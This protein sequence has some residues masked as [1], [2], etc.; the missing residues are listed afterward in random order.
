MPNRR[1]PLNLVDFTG[2]LNLRSNQFQLAA[3]ESPQME[4][5]TIDPLGGIYSRFGW[6]RWNPIDIPVTPATWDPRRAFLHQLA[7]GTDNV[8][9][10]ANNKVWMTTANRTFVDS[11]LVASAAVHVADF[12]S[13][14]DD[15]YIACG[16][17]RQSARRRGL[18]APALLTSA[19]V[20][21]WNDDYTNPLH[22]VMPQ[23]ALCEQHGGY[24][25][26]ART[27]EDGVNFPN[28][29][30]WSHPTSQ[31]DWAHDDYIDIG[32]GG[33]QIVALQ[34][35]EDHLLIF[36][37]DGIWALYGYNAESWQLIQ[38]SS[39]I[40]ATSPQSVTRSEGA[41]F[42]YSASDRGGIYAYNGERPIEISEQLRYAMENLIDNDLIWVGWAGRKLW[43]T[44]PWTYDGPSNDNA[45][46]FLFDP[47]IGE[48]GSWA[49][50]TSEAGGL[51]PIVGGSNI[52][53]QTKP[54][55]VLR[56]TEY[57]CLVQLNAINA[58]V[59]QVA[60]EAVLG[61]TTAPLQWD[62]PVIL[63]DSGKAILA[64]GAPGL[65]PFR[66][67]YRTPWM[68]A[69]WPT[70][71]K[72]WRR[73]DFVCRRTGFSYRLSVRS[74]RDYEE[75]NARRS[76][77][78]FVEGGG[79][80]VWGAFDWKAADDETAALWGVGTSSGGIIRRGSSYGM[81][82]ALQLNIEGATRGARW[83]IDAIVL[84]LVFRRFQ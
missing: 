28:R 16:M 71:K 4:N 15:V 24:L 11:G 30:R 22:Q 57:P 72:S 78:V 75:L 7:D 44:L 35:Y 5:I 1:E 73:P 31:D 26:V 49:Y 40:G 9:I 81:A 76:S 69:D 38:K 14:G 45:G 54:L 68:T 62:Q 60:N 10:A 21:T 8:Y 23:A 42:F 43:V 52:D 37:A 83:G 34:T 74:Y 64:S 80:T 41:V 63:T 33:S 55:G 20:S 29:V 46:V 61:A 53:S 50:Y 6:E 70:R 48:N 65:Q 59:D 18:A 27:S 84:K 17:G 36:K 51:G 82:R 66:T 13:F 47:S 3:N 12:C 77:Q 19:G 67:Q 79:K 2:G 58:A 39:T 32:A 56:N 25:F